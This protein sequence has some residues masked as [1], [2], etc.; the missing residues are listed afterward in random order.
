MIT[1]V[2]RKNNT[3]EVA[4]HATIKEAREWMRRNRLHYLGRAVRDRDYRYLF[5]FPA[6]E[7]D[8]KKMEEYAEDH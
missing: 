6:T 2:T 8:R 3:H 5:A 7:Q 4:E 1:L